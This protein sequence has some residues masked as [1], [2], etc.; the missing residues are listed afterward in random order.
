MNEPDPNYTQSPLDVTIF[1]PLVRREIMRVRR[2]RRRAQKR[3]LAATLT[4]MQWLRTLQA[5]EWRCAYCRGRF[6]T[7]DHVVP[8]RLGGGTT[9][10]NCVPCCLE[11]NQA[12]ERLAV[13]ADAALVKVA[14]LHGNGV[15]LAAAD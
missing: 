10:E 12:R 8:L 14:G 1:F 13:M 9:A 11:H 7:L 15:N 3:G 5:Y 6:E 4:P 2:H